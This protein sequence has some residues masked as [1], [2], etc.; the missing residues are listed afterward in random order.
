MNTIPPELPTSPEKSEA[1]PIVI[2]GGPLYNGKGN[3]YE[4][5]AVFISKG[6]VVAAGTEESVFAHIPKTVDIEVYDTLGC[7]IF[8]G[9]INL[10]HHFSRSFALGLPSYNPNNGSSAQ[11]ENFGWKYD[12]CLDDDMVQLATLVGILNS[13]KTGITTVFDLHSSPLAISKILENIESLVS[14]SG[15]Q[16]VLSYEISERNGDDIFIRSLEENRS[17]I[18]NSSLDPGV[19][20]M[21][22]IQVAGQLSDRALTLIAEAAGDTSGFHIE[23]G[24]ENNLKRLASFSLINSK[25]LVSGG[26]PL[27]NDDL[28]T[29]QE[30]GATFVQTP[31]FQNNQTALLQSDIRQGIGTSGAG[32]GVLQALN[33]E[34]NRYNSPDVDFAKLSDYIRTL[35][36]GNVEFAGRYFNG[37]PGVIETDSNADV[38]V[39]DYIPATPVTGDN[40]LQHL[41]WGMQHTPAKM[42]MT[43]GRFI[44]NN[45]T[46]L[47]LD[48]EIILEESQKAARRLHEKFEKL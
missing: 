10:H 43:R 46:F 40:Y 14:R 38:V 37:K 32:I 24:A 31:G 25:S 42:V 34:F 47:T 35:M 26:F 16:A 21:F 33:V 18:R 39:F 4:D 1:R 27:G 29:L 44:Y 23:L 11:L 7:V 8:P 20:G 48:E 2:Y 5:G 13:I 19:R 30:S 22:G 45:Y 12:L 36:Q 6:K 41:L 9:L 3:I 15:I 17:F 28:K